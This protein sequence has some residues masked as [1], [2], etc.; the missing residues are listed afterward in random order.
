MGT[1]F[2]AATV[3]A[4]INPKLLYL[5]LVDPLVPARRIS[6]P[7]GKLAMWFWHVSDE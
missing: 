4:R 1:D 2:R 3:A 7:Y 6:A 5:R